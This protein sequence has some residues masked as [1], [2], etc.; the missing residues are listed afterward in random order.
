[1]C[2]AHDGAMLVEAWQSKIDSA[3]HYMIELVRTTGLR[4]IR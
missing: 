3:R 4:S 1:L 2:R